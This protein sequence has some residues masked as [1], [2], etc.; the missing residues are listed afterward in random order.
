MRSQQLNHIASERIHI[1][2]PIVIRPFFPKLLL[3]GLAQPPIDLLL[4]V[5]DVEHGRIEVARR[6]DLHPD[7]REQLDFH[8]R[9]RVVAAP[10]D[11]FPVVRQERLTFTVLHRFVHHSDVLL[12]RWTNN[13]IGGIHDRLH[14]RVIKVTPGKILSSIGSLPHP[15]NAIRLLVLPDF[16]CDRLKCS[17]QCRHPVLVHPGSLSSRGERRTLTGLPLATCRIEDVT[18][19]VGLHPTGL[20]PSLNHCLRDFG[21]A[22]CVFLRRI[23][24]LVRHLRTT[25]LASFRNPGNQFVFLGD[26]LGYQMFDAR[27]HRHLCA[28]QF[29]FGV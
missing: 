27:I 1:N 26:V 24:R 20:R 15:N 28:C 29:L 14:L 13:V 22:V 5:T 12:E 4:E 8:P 7:W 21:C 18:G 10:G 16:F 9:L 17:N 2:A 3:P 19:L 25:D 23:T 11:R 6:T